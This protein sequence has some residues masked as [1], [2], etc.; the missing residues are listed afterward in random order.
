MSVSYYKKANND[1]FQRL[2][3]YIYGL[4]TTLFELV[5]LALFKGK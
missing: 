2:I 5:C 1:Y 4:E 3:R